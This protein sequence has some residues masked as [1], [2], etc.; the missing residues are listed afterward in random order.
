MT[1]M[2]NDKSK[3]KNWLHKL[4]NILGD[5]V[6]DDS[7]SFWMDIAEQNFKEPDEIKD[8]GEIHDSTG[9]QKFSYDSVAKGLKTLLTEKF[10]EDT[11]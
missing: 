2:G 1:K 3:W 5:A 10:D 8:Q 4:K 9:Q 6:K 7:W 11:D